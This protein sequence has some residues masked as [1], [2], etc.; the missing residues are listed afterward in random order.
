[1]ALDG[2]GSASGVIGCG[3]LCTITLD[4]L[5]PRNVLC[6]TEVSVWDRSGVMRCNAVTAGPL[7]L[8]R[9]C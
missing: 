3:F 9:H 6:R 7:H 2:V 5:F 1:M 4:G 8:F